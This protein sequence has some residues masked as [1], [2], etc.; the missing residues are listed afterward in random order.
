MRRLGVSF[1]FVLVGLLL[2]AVAQAQDQPGSIGEKTAWQWNMM[3]VRATTA[4]HALGSAEGVV[5]VL[6]T[7][8]DFLHRDLEEARWTN[9]EEVAANGIDD[10]GN[11][12]VD[13]V[14]GW[15]FCT[16]RPTDTTP[17]DD[18]G[19]QVASLVAADGRLHRGMNGVAPGA[20]LADLRILCAT[21]G[22][23]PL[24]PKPDAFVRLRDALAYARSEKVNVAVIG[25]LWNEDHEMGVDAIVSQVKSELQNASAAGIFLV[26]GAGNTHGGRVARPGTYPAVVAVGAVGL[27]NGKPVYNAV[28]PEIELWAPGGIDPPGNGSA[29]RGMILVASGDGGYVW[30]SG[31]TL[32]A[33]HVAGA[34]TRLLARDPSQFPGEL[35]DRLRETAWRLADVSPLL[36]VAAALGLD[37]ERPEARIVSPAHGDKTQ[38]HFAPQVAYSRGHDVY[39]I[40]LILNGE[41]SRY[42]MTVYEGPLSL[43][44]PAGPSYT[45]EVAVF[46]GRQLHPPSDKIV[47][48]NDP[49]APPPAQHDL[50]VDAG[51][52]P[53][54]PARPAP[55]RS[56]PG[57]ELIL[58]IGLAAFVR[59]L[60]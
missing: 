36:D 24:I 11:G 3:D 59:R 55:P 31:T 4:Q 38:L 53:D 14:H 2:P 46:D 29:D 1:T 10:D 52:D 30:Q 35:L 39:S 42:A 32:A 34:A 6:D 7:G 17:L 48:H 23:N 12:Y 44:A 40:D 45:F 18:H 37:Y 19:T 54:W 33:A 5:A 57:L 41:T 26:A 49:K 8:I 15:D 43:R 28:G 25:L 16:G 13:D 9:P 20:K 51:D 50:L 21:D 60:R 27:G 47:L 22:A 58:L 56:V